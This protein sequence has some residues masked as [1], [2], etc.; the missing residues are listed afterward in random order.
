MTT[1]T[2]RG[3]VRNSLDLKGVDYIE[4]YVGNAYQA[5]HFYR[6]AFG[7]RRVA[8]AG[9]E[10]GV[11]DRVSFM[12]TQQ[13]I[14]LVLTSPLDLA[15]PIAEHVNLHCDGVKDI[16]FT[17]EDA[18]AAFTEA[19]RRG[20]RPVMEP[21]AFDDGN[22]RF[23]KS[24]IATF[25]DTVHSFIERSDYDG[26]GL[27]QSIPLAESYTVTAATNLSKVDH[28]AVAMPSGEVEPWSDF[29]QSVFGFQQSLAE[30]TLGDYSGMNTKAL[31]ND[32]G[33]VI[34]VLVEPLT[35]LRKSPIDEFLI[36]Y[37]GSGVHHIALGTSNII[38]TVAG[39]RAN[40]IEFAATP[41]TYYDDL[42][43]RHGELTEDTAA[44]RDLNIL[45]DRDEWGYLLQIFSRPLQSRPTLFF[46]IIQRVG[47]RGFGG[48]NIKALFEAIERD[49][50]RRGNI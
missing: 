5:A 10:T 16:A 35:G 47:A 1:T 9:P 31:Q 12:V 8:Y 40:G 14:K 18:T 4:L 27:A 25:G 13:D 46:E 11:R 7:F 43:Q 49:Q 17:V 34:T 32:S 48:G 38:E 6:A 24:T 37:K 3:G 15:G 21:M 44:L 42:K 20:A 19:V 26:G 33:S 2:N 39:L 36:H 29:Y 41:A 28:I 23:I 22:G 30:N 45:V 50:V